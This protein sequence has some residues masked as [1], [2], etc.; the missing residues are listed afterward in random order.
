MDFCVKPQWIFRKE[1]TTMY[2][3]SMRTKG[4]ALY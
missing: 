2:L 4:G 1:N 3:N